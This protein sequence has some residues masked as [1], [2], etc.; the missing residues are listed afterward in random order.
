MERIF[1]RLPE[2]TLT[3][4]PFVPSIAC[5]VFLLLLQGSMNN[6]SLAVQLPDAH[7]L[8]E[9][10]LEVRNAAYQKAYKPV[11]VFCLSFVAYVA[12]ASIYHLPLP[13]SFGEGLVMFMS[14]SI[15]L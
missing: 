5:L 3:F 7:S 13:K 2:F 14:L 11:G 6:T 1:G 15:C 8:D 9:R 12:F 4:I 10:Q